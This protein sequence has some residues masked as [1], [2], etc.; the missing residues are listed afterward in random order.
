MCLRTKANSY[1][2]RALTNDMKISLK[3]EY[4]C[5]ALAQIGRIYGSGQ[6]AHIED[7]SNSEKIPRNYL[8][9]ILNRLNKGGILVSKRGKLGGYSLA[10]RPA[11]ITLLDIA[12]IVDRELV[13]T[14]NHLDG[15]S[16]V[17]VAE[18]WNAISTRFHNAL[19]ATTV[20]DLI[21]RYNP[22][23]DYSI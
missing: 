7:I 23:G 2:V 4:A 1:V 21:P 17:Q 13:Q 22:A 6:L 5:R 9:Q 18:I 11:E 10:K 8:I 16:G 3:L 15:E 14:Q 12:K 20:A 19:Q